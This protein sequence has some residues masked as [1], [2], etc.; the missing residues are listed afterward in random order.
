MNEAARY[1]LIV[2][3]ASGFTGK[4]A[5][6]YIAEN[7][8]SSVHWA[9]AGRNRDKLEAVKNQL[10][11]E[12]DVLVADSLDVEAINKLVASTRV[13]LTT[14][15]P[16]ALYGEPLI[17]ACAELGVDYVDIT[18]ETPFIRQ[19]MDACEAT[20]ISTGAKIVPFCGFDS[21]PS[22]IGTLLLVE[23]FRAQGK[24]TKQVKAFHKGKGGFNGGTAASMLNMMRNPEIQR[25][26]SDPMLLNPN[27]MRHADEALENMDPTLPTDDPD[28]GHWVAP[29]IMGPINTRVVRRS[30]ALES[31]R[32]AAYGTGFQYQEYMNLGRSASFF[33]STA[34][35]AVAGTMNL[36]GKIPG[37][38]N[39]LE[40]IVPKPGE[41]PS[42]EAMDNGF[43]ECLLVGT[44]EDGSKAWAEVSGKGDPGN[45][46]TLMF[47]CESALCLLCD[48]DAL[49]GGEPRA[50][51]LTPATAFGQVLVK[52][53]QEA[54]MTLDCPVE[55]PALD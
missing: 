30:N 41:G 2:Y 15:G 50:G 37:A 25:E 21:I 27:H 10:G 16:Y 24:G 20:A 40:K 22:D 39:L 45:R 17:K 36:L 55:R 11:I 7:A 3:G 46:A 19:M 38:P 44:A 23:Y 26:L 33:S 52:R 29:F 43:F 12:V 6:A 8:P 31:E 18:G 42:E 14:V 1:D 53:L 13:I 32:Q 28:L 54:G 4:Q 5:A 51:F 34:V 48:R 35:S 49:P 47:L 9:I